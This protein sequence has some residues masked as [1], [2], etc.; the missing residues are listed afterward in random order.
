MATFF[1]K[2]LARLK[3]ERMEL[4]E[5]ELLKRSTA[6]RAGTIDE[7]TRRTVG[8]L[9]AGGAS[10]T[11]IIRANR[12][13]YEAI[14]EG[15]SADYQNA[16]ATLQ[17]RLD[18]SSREIDRAEEGRE[19]ERRQREAR[20]NGAM[21][22]ILSAGGA[23]LGGAVG[24]IIPGAGTMLGAQIGAG[25][26]GLAGGFVGGGGDMGINYADEE[27]IS[28]GI[29]DTVSGISAATTL[30]SQ[31]EFINEVGGFMSTPVYKNLS[32]EKKADFRM[33][34]AMQD[35]EGIRN[36]YRGSY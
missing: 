30:N 35:L 11:A 22:G 4:P 33:L 17:G 6:D 21:R 32:A 2:K 26:G 15:N 36:F 1:E 7:L 9:K 10:P 25:L 20:K 16:Q 27:A 18:A 19:Q 31:K 13:G 28:Q 29:A 23:V 14:S 34:V 8:T 3:R 5:Y 24:S 12:E